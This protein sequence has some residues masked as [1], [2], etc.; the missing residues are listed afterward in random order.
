MQRST[1]VG[2][3]GSSV[4]DDYRTSYG[5]FI[6]RCV[7][8]YCG[9]DGGIDD[10]DDDM[11]VMIAFMIVFLCEATRVTVVI[12]ATAANRHCGRAQSLITPAP[13]CPR[14]PTAPPTAP[15]PTPTPPQTSRYQTDIVKRMEDRIA[16]L[17]HLP[18]THQEDVQV[19]R[20]GI[21]Q[22]RPG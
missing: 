3:N 8:A 20:Y 16:L 6:S 1:V 19:L 12:R 15:H 13:I 5:T 9:D 22:V 17:T 11:V 21:G 10:D 7:H 4:L 14:M 2:D 18:V